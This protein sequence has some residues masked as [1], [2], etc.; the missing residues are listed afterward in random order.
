M[1]RTSLIALSAA[2]VMALGLAS[3]ASAKT[4]FN[5]NVDLGFGSG[6]FCH[7]EYVPYKKWNYWHT[8]YKI[9]FKKVLVCD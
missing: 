1:I 2:T 4:S 8:A 9:K 6:G 5:I 7:Y 3:Q